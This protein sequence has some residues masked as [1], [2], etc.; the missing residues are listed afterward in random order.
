MRRIATLTFALCAAPAAA[1]DLAWTFAEGEQAP[2]FAAAASG[3]A[4][5]RDAGPK[6]LDGKLYLLQSWWK[7]TA[8][9]AFPAPAALPAATVDASFALIMNT[10]GEGAGF[11]WLDA[12]RFGAEGPAPEVEAWEAPSIAGSFG[13]GFDASNP[14]NRDPFRGS[15]N[16]YDRPQH[17]V[18]LH[19]DGMEIAKKTT[20]LDFRDEQP[21]AV[22][23]HLA[24]V[25]GGAEATVFIDG[26]AVFERRFI[27]GMTAYAGRPAF[28]ARNVE[29]AG[30]VLI[31]DLAVACGATVEPA[32]PPLRVPA[33]ERVL[34]DKDHALNA[35]EVDFPAE[36]ARFGRIVCTLRLDQPE[37]RFDPWDR[38]AAIYAYDDEG[39]RFEIL[40]YITPYHRGHVWQVDVSDF[41]P[42]LSGRRRIEQVCTTYGEGWVVTVAFDFYPGPCDLLACRVVNLWCGNPEIGNPEKPVA[43][44]YAPRSVELDKETAAAKV[45]IVVTGHGMHPNTRNAAEFMEIGRTLTVNGESFRNVLW[46]TDNY[47][48]PCRPQGGTWKYDRAGWAPGDVVAPWEVDV[49]ALL[50]GAKRLDLGYAL[51]DY[52][53]E[54]R[55]QS[56]AP[57]HTTESQLIL[58][59]RP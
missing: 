3:E 40:R 8:S 56:W 6:A 26:E 42:L 28:G 53:N 51:D 41:R 15:G 31:D 17:E 9:A 49:T 19:W 30:D 12:G 14:P 25:T 46:K 7:S 50:L 52:V 10:G 48:N 37:T 44:F 5:E 4:A 35:A 24:F 43:D 33:L 57:T 21:H 55:G 29:T 34:N 2:P 1:Q 20:A 38:F 58:Y 27:P 18:S 39:E 54:A 47:L 11:A 45:R 36:N 23:I 22:A 13:V 59:R 32:E 16:A